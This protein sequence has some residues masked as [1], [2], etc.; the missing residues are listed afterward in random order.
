MQ[1]WIVEAF[2]D[3]HYA[4]NDAAVILCAAGFPPVRRMQ[5]I[6]QQ[7]G[8]PTTAFVLHELGQKYR[9]RWF[10][11]KKELDLCGHATIASA[12]YLYDVANVC[13]SSKLCFYAR[14]GP[15]YACWNGSD[16]SLDLP[17]M[18]V[19][20][21]RPPEGLESALGATVVH[22]ARATDD[23]LI[24][25]ESERLIA[26][27]RPDFCAL[28]QIACRGHVVTARGEGETDFVSRSF[29]PALGVNEDQVCVSAHCK[30]GPYWGAKLGKSQMTGLQLSA[31]GGRLRVEVTDRRVYVA[32]PARVRQCIPSWVWATGDRSRCRPRSVAHASHLTVLEG[33]PRA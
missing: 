1:A 21:C 11:P 2:A 29:F 17:R 32:G 31:R 7:L 13:R 8:V 20:P 28:A 30:L 27:L 4:G 19:V 15:L 9:I 18:D 16:L 23:I 25:L 33:G 22:C 5:S 24:E 10:T 3:E 26:A 6:A 12:C 14:S